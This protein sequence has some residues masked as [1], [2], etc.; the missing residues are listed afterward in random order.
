[1]IEQFYY[2]YIYVYINFF[3][4]LL[5]EILCSLEFYDDDDDDDAINVVQ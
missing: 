1:M 4:P 2:I 3:V 5:K